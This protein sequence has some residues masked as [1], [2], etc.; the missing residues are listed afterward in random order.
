LLAAPAPTGG[1]KA[2]TG[3]PANVGDAGSRAGTA[4]PAN[5]NGGI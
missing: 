2:G 3:P 4:P 1:G 5:V